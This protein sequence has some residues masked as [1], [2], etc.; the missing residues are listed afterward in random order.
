MPTEWVGTMGEN[1]LYTCHAL[2]PCMSM[3]KME[4]SK[5]RFV[6][7]QY[8]SGDVYKSIRHPSRN[9]IRAE[10]GR[11]PKARPTHGEVT[12]QIPEQS[13]ELGDGGDEGEEGAVE[14]VSCQIS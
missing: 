4:S 3:L 10:A 11:E 5:Q 1:G 6:S 14:L 2:A 13:G 9:A 8:G 12:D 7:V